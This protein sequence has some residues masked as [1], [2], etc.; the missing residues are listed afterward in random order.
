MPRELLEEGAEHLP[1][2]LQ[3]L[4]KEPLD[5]QESQRAFRRYGLVEVTETWLLVHRLVQAVTQDRIAAKDRLV[6]VKAAV[7]TVDASFPQKVLSTPENWAK[8]ERLLP[9]AL[10]VAAHAEVLDVDV[11]TTPRL[12]NQTGI[13]FHARGQYRRAQ[14]LVE[15]SLALRERIQGA[16]HPDTGR[17]P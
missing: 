1:E 5:W 16:E 12:L 8:C 13:Y 4:V 17:K 14:G 6:W 3:A 2:R 15:R 9:H 7:Q 10:S 11:G